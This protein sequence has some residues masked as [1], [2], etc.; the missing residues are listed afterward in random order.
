MT[1]KLNVGEDDVY[2][3]GKYVNAKGNTE[4][5]VFVQQ[6]AG[7]P[8]TASWRRGQRVEDALPGAIPRGTV[9]ATFDGD[10]YPTDSNGRHAAIYLSHDKTGI[11][12]LD[13]WNAQGEVKK[14]TI[15]FNRPKGTS[16]SNNGDTFYV[17]E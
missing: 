2:G 10:H 12:V 3:K 16:R 11:Q 5:V 6:A 15:R 17:V 4:C 7:A 9:I 14:R 8:P 1:Y 13:Q